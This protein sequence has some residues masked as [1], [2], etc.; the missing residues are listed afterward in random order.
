MVRLKIDANKVTV[1]GID[2]LNKQI[3]NPELQPS[4]FIY[5]STPMPIEVIKLFQICD[6]DSY[7]TRCTLQVRCKHQKGR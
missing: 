5:I 7:M 3:L 1:I 2:V 4:I 6:R